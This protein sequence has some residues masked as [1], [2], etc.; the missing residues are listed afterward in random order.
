MPSTKHIESSQ[1]T[2]QSKRKL[3][4]VEYEDPFDHEQ[5]RPLTRSRSLSEHR[6]QSQNSRVSLV[7]NLA[8]YLTT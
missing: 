3:F 2:I 8:S 6:K 1:S 4:E 5:H 7:Y